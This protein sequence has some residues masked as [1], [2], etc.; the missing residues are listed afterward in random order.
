MRA[1][2]Y[3]GRR[4]PDAERRRK[5]GRRS[6][7]ALPLTALSVDLPGAIIEEEKS[8]S[9]RRFR[10]LE[11]YGEAAH[12]NVLFDSSPHSRAAAFV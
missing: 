7:P 2:G 12:L 8:R 10:S 5:R 11:V 6:D 3:D 1:R 4:E 9:P